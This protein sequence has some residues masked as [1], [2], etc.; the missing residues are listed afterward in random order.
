MH[1]DIYAYRES[2]NCEDSLHGLLYS[3]EKALENG[4]HALVLFLDLTA[5]FSTVTIEG[6][7]KNL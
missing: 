3:I 5:A 6:V 4:E 1:K 2:M 7:I